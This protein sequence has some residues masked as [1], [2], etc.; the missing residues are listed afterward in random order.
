[1]IDYFITSKPWKY[2]LYLL[3][4][5]WAPISLFIFGMGAINAGI[6]ALYLL[7]LLITACYIGVSRG[8]LFSPP[9]IV[10]GMSMIAIGV[11]MRTPLKIW[12]R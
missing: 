9:C 6:I 2:W 8:D 11:P 5:I 1:M 7:Y 10:A 12:L 3:L 4:I